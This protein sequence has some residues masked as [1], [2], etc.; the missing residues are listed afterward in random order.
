MEAT[1]DYRLFLLRPRVE[2][3]SVRALAEVPQLFFEQVSIS[4]QLALVA[5]E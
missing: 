5:L 3:S 2:W 1:F 4:S